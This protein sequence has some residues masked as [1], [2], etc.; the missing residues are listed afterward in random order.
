MSTPTAYE[1]D[2]DGSKFIPATQR[3]DGTWRKPRRI[4][5]GYVP[6]EE[7]PLY[8]SK[9]K[10]FRARQND[11]L[12]VGLTPEIVAQAQKKKGQRS[13]IQPIP[14][15]IITVEK[16]KKKKKTVTGVEEAAE[17]LA[18]CE[19]QEPTLPSQSVPTESISQSDPTKRLKNLRKK[20]REIEFLEEKIKA[21]LL[22]SPDKDQKEKMSKKNEILNEI[23]ILKNSIL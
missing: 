8:E 4:K 23:D 1:H 17:K 16:K 2:A 14:G 18:K 7:V 21:G 20:L 3:P 15:M 12:P 5:E 22:K 13:T 6:Q 9:G 10:Q 11:G 19:I